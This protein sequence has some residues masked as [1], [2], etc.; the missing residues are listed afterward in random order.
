MLKAYQN[1]INNVTYSS[2]D[3]VMAVIF[4]NDSLDFNSVNLKYKIV[5]SKLI[6][7]YGHCLA[8]LT[9]KEIFTQRFLKLQICLDES[10]VKMKAKSSVFDLRVSIKNFL[11]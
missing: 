7:H 6:P 3:E 2:N 8:H 1:K 10:F 5:I 4:L 11:Q 9:R